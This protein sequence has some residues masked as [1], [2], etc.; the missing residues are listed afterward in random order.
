M[1]S[2]N[3]GHVLFQVQDLLR[4][5][6]LRPHESGL[7]AFQL[8]VW[9]HLSAKDKL[10]VDDRADA[11]LQYG[12]SGIVEALN[13]LALLEGALGQAFSD[14][15]RRAQFSGDYIVAALMSAKRLAEGGIFERF[16]PAEISADLLQSSLD[17][18]PVPVELATLMAHLTVGGDRTS[19]YCPWESSGQFIGAL[20]RDNVSLY[21]ETPNLSP[22]P[23]LLSLFREAPT[24]LVLA[25]PLRSPTAIKGGHLEK[26]DAA[27]SFPP[28]GMQSNDDVA[29]Q[30]LYGRFPV[31]KATSTGLMVQHILAQ[32]DG[33]AA[34][35]VPNSFLF[36]PGKDRDV[37]EYLLNKGW[38][39]AV[40]ALP[41]GMHQATNLL[42][43]LLLLNTQANH[44]KVGFIDASLPHF[45]QAY[46][47]GRVTLANLDDIS[48]FCYAL[49][50]ADEHRAGRWLDESLAVVTPVEEILSKEA[51]LQVDRYVM[52]D[53]QRDLQARLGAMPTV[54]LEE[55]AEFHNPIPNKDRNSDAPSAIDVYEVG[56]ADL[57]TAGYIEIPEKREKTVSVQLSSRRSGSAED[58][59]L[60]PGDVLLITKG[61]V[62]KVGIVPANVPPAG[63]GGWVAG[64]SAIVMRGRGAFSDLRGL[65][66]WLR[67][68]MGKNVLAGITSGATIPMISIQ[69]LR[70]LQVP[71]LTVEATHRAAG[72]LDREAA[73]QHQIETLRAEQSSLSEQL[74]SELLK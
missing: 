33:T 1:S 52:A 72:V 31:K 12:A 20:M 25:N 28:I 35:V 44:R 9:S 60:R 26:F 5:S 11:A 74:W 27:L 7:L 58:V 30:D 18:L 57:P 3:A 38:V 55:V 17:H 14:A 50:D 8:L 49:L 71:T 39:E 62:G 40:I 36:G 59:F 6:S 68:Q 65:G 43:A 54:S 70:R 24:T 45:R 37:R 42:T 69:T 46:G 13:R 63:P 41:A 23:A 4:N 51:S 53:E 21:A 73:I 56:A 16:S 64:Q 61:S 32:T 48:N 66:L 34:I 47:K 15:P 2:D 19:A 29:G 10:E 67:S 22:L